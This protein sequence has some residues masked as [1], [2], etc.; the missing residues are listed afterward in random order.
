MNYPGIIVN[1]EYHHTTAL[2]LYVS[3][4]K[5]N[6]KPVFLYCC[7]RD[8]F[9][10]QHMCGVMGLRLTDKQ[11]DVSFVITASEK[12]TGLCPGLS[13]FNRNKLIFVHHRPLS[14]CKLDTAHMHIANGIYEK[15][16][17]NNF[18]YQCEMP[19]QFISSLREDKI[20]VIARFNENKINTKFIL[21]NIQHSM[22]F[23]GMGSKAFVEKNNLN[24]SFYDFCDNLAFYRNLNRF[25]FLFI[26]Y[27]MEQD[28][29]YFSK[30]ISETVTLSIAYKIPIIAEK[31][32]L[33][34]HNIQGIPID[35]KE[36]YNYNML[37]NY[38]QQYQNESRDHNKE[39]LSL[40]LNNL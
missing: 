20:A 23:V 33:E 19:Q 15:T 5:I 10:F 8:R 11:P 4:E 36:A 28:K 29:D 7:D 12:E 31:G 1:T 13:R 21:N 24:N 35:N 27:S 26:P 25:K 40:Y 17:S 18:F 37:L 30:K 22:E 6:K 39:V 2:S 32:F 9:K 34:F 14:D 3:L 16:F 38:L